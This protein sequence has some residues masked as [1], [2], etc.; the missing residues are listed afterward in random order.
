MIRYD[1]APGRTLL[2]LLRPGGFLAPLLVPRAVAGLPLDV[3]FRER[4]HVHV[5][6]GQTR[7]L[8]V[9]IVRGGVRVDAHETYASQSGATGLCRTWSV[10]EAGLHA[11]LDTYLGSVVVGAR[12]IAKEGA[13]QVAW[14]SVRQPWMPL[15][16]EAVLGYGANDRA[17]VFPEVQ[18]ARVALEVAR[19]THGWAALPPTKSAAELDQLAIDSG[20]RLVL[21][22]LKDAASSPA[23]VS[24]SPLQLLQYVHEWAAAYDAVRPGL[25]KLREAR[26]EVGL[27][28]ASMPRL[29][30][31]LRPVIGFGEDTR[32]AE[33]RARFNAVME[34][35]NRYLPPGT[36]PIEVWSVWRGTAA[37]I[38][39]PSSV[40]S[41]G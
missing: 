12:W 9:S 16:R 30:D 7:L 40:P 2:D 19:A 26:V 37:M 31:G 41:P 11:A 3:H 6:C 29:T 18:A 25:D 28:P 33:V 27:S 38:P 15:D 35:V 13:V 32:S 24:Y 39:P 20:G 22:E 34:V 1:R 14:A 36:P 23:S 17:R 8:D 10:G 4:D 5:Y 21:V